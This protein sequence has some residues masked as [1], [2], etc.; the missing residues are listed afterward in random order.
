MLAGSDGP[1]GIYFDDAQLAQAIGVLALAF[2]LFS[3]GLDTPWR[4]VRPALKSALSLATLGVLLTSVVVGVTTVFVLHFSWLEGLLLGAIIA[5]TDAAAVF[6]V[7]R[8]KRLH[9]TGRLSQVLELESATNDPMA[10]FL[11]IGVIQLLTHPAQPPLSLVLF[12]VQQMGIGL[13]VGL[14]LGK[15]AVLFIKYLHLEVEGLYP[16]ASVALVLL[17]YG[18]TTMLGGSGF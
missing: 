10:V 8:S 16:V 11:T 7:L 18:L 13:I 12:F 4:D 14:L 17:T 6:S 3:A 15:G 2:I 5:S 1:G 9:L